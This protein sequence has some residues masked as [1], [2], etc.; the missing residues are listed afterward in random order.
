M[1][2]IVGVLT[3]FFQPVPLAALDLYAQS[4]SIL[5][6]RSSPQK[7]ALVNLS[8][9]VVAV[10]VIFVLGSL[11]GEGPSRSRSFYRSFIVMFPL[12]GVYLLYAMTT[13]G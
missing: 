2:L 1:G 5:T 7:Y 4:L 12:P 6:D 13:H 3:A 8:V 10:A 9:C 11:V